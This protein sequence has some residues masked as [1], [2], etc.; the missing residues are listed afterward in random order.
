HHPAPLRVDPPPLLHESPRGAEIFGV[1]VDGCRLLAPA[2]LT[3]S[4]LVVPQYVVAGVG[5]PASELRKHGVPRNVLVT[6]LKAGSRN[7]D[8]RGVSSLRV[9]RPRWLAERPGEIE[10]VPGEC[11]RLVARAAHDLHARGYGGGILVHP[12]QRLRWHLE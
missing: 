12:E 8:D 6:T 9:R 2:A 11:H 7:Q 3:G 5:E 10:S 4:P 1:V